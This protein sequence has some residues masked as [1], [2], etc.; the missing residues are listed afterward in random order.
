MSMIYGLKVFSFVM[1]LFGNI[2]SLAAWERNLQGNPG[3]VD[4]AGFGMDL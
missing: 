2:V 3:F 4:G 1:K